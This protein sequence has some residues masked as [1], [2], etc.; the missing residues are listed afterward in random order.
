M[1]SN[2]KND[3][4]CSTRDKIPETKHDITDEFKTSSYNIAME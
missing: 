4:N 1:V 2:F 3:G